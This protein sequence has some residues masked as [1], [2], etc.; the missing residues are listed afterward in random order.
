MYVC[1][2]VCMY[3]CTHVS[4]YVLMYIC[5]HVCVYMYVY[6]CVY[7]MHVIAN[8]HEQITKQIVPAHRDKSLRMA[9]NFAWLLLNG[10]QIAIPGVRAGVVGT[11]TL[12][13]LT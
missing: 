6:I 12:I 3:A 9:L 10:S 4:M 8:I 1:M 2:Y 5:M 11:S 7:H 13:G